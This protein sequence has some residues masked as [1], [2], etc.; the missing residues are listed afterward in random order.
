MSAETQVYQIALFLVCIVVVFYLIKLLRNRKRSA[1]IN[2]EKSYRDL[3]VRTILNLL[4]IP[5][6]TY[7]AFSLAFLLGQ[8]GDWCGRD[9]TGDAALFI[10]P[11]I[12]LFVVFALA[13]SV[14]ERYPEYKK[15]VKSFII[16][17]GLVLNPL[18]FILTFNLLNAMCV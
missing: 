11:F 15:S 4:F 13:S 12:G 17:T 2:I 3:P 10:V 9:S 14:K 8:R 18:I 7:F 1:E 16:W 5:S 6:L